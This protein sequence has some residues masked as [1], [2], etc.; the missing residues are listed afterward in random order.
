MF[1]FKFSTISILIL[2]Q[3]YPF[4]TVRAVPP[5]FIIHLGGV[6]SARSVKLLDRIHNP[7]DYMQLLFFQIVLESPILNF[8]LLDF[9]LSRFSNSRHCAVGR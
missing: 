9:L 7:G 3:E 6:V 8:Q 4:F 1:F 2:S 5:D